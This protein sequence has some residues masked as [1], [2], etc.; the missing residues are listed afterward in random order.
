MSASRKNR[1]SRR[2]VRRTKRPASSPMLIN[3]GLQN[4]DL[5]L[6]ERLFVEA[7]A[8]GWATT[9]HFDNLADMR[10]C[11]LLAAALKKDGATIRMCRAAGIALM[12][13]RDRYAETKRMAVSADELQA[14]RVFV[15][16]YRDFWLRQSVEAY[17]EACNALGRARAINSLEVEEM[18]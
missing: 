11:L 18:S 14:L 13:I 10:D 12:N 1:P 8:G 4:T 9:E 17:E 6:R 16:A 15:T 2:T 5:E 3:R 7:F